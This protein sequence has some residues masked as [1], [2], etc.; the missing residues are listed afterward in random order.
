M[1]TKQKRAAVSSDEKRRRQFQ[2]NQA[3][4]E[5]IQ[6][7]G[8]SPAETAV[9]LGMSIAAVNRRNLYRQNPQHENPRSARRFRRDD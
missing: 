7:R 5:R 3:I 1:Q 6:K 4:R 8:Y 2:S 9:A